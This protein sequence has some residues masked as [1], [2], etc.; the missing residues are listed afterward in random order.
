MLLKHCLPLLATEDKSNNIQLFNRNDSV[1]QIN[2]WRVF[3]Y[4]FTPSSFCLLFSLYTYQER[5]FTISLL[6]LE[7]TLAFVFEIWPIVI[8][9][10]NMNLLKSFTRKNHIFSI[11]HENCSSSSGIFILT[12]LASAKIFPCSGLAFVLA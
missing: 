5:P 3:C 2:A 12:K 9:K 7:F 1:V 11:L 10:L 4:L 6:V 8:F